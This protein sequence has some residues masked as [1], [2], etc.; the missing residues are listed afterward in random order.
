MH[1]DTLASRDRYRG[2]VDRRLPVVFINGYAEGLDAPFVSD[3]DVAAMDLA[4]NHL[5]QLGHTRIGLAVGPDHYVPVQRKRRGFVSALYSTLGLPPDQAAAW[6][7][8]GFFSVEGGHAAAQLLLDEGCTAVICGSDMMALGV[9]RAARGRGLDV[10]GDVSVVG[11]DD[12]PL[13]AFTDPPLTTVRQSVDAMGN[14]AVRALLDE[15]NGTPAPHAEYVFRPS[16][17]SA[18]PPG[19]PR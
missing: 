18:D 7:A 6:V 1:A 8:H 14:A 13:I 12:S 11:Y 19:L 5:V 16:S 2:L 3:D 10:P 9:V 15:I 4:V 17:S